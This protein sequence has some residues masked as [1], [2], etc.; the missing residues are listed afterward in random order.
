MGVGGPIFSQM[1]FCTSFLPPLFFWAVVIGSFSWEE[2]LLVQR[3]VRPPPSPLS[4]FAEY[5]KPLSGEKT[6]IVVV[7]RLPLRAVLWPPKRAWNSSVISLS[8]REKEREG[9]LVI[10]MGGR[11]V[12]RGRKR[13][14]WSEKGGPLF[15]FLFWAMELLF[16][17]DGG[18]VFCCCCGVAEGDIVPSMK[19][20]NA[21]KFELSMLKSKATK[22]ETRFLWLFR[23]LMF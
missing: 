10:R 9:G 7:L 4:A 1:A 22:R 14:E 13:N 21:H 16:F 5:G 11:G 3:R 6:A 2:V 8:R 17:W 15:H 23:I 20:D 12:S 18:N 19:I